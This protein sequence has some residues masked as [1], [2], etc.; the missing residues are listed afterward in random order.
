MFGPLQPCFPQD[1][2]L[3][4][5][6]RLRRVAFFCLIELMGRAKVLVQNLLD[7]FQVPLCEA[8]PSKELDLSCSSERDWAR[9]L[10]IP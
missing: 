9:A 6:K 3:L 7:K 1:G 4:R 8:A 5:R 10:W 2:L